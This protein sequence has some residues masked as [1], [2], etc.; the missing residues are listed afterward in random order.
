[1]RGRIDAVF[2]DPD[3]GV[4]IVDWKTGRPGS[5]E[6]QRLRALQ[7]AVYRVAYA[8]LTGRPADQVR[9]AFFFAATGQ[10]VRPPLL[11]EAELESL[12]AD[13]TS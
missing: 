10:T 7:L 6:Q 3:G 12:L 11:G 9:A 5:P 13:L 4:T 8:R 1:V 2:D